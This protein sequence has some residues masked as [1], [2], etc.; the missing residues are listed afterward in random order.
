MKY[1]PILIAASLFAGCQQPT[2]KKTDS[3]VSTDTPAIPAFSPAGKSVYTYTTADKTDF[4]LA[5]TDTLTFSEMGQPKETQICVF[6]DPKRTYQTFMGIGGAITDASAE[7]LAKL[8]ADKQEELLKAYFDKEKGIGYSLLRTN[9]MSCDFSSGSYS[10]VQ[11]G[12]KELK[13]FSVEHDKQ[14]RIPMIKRAITAAGGTIPLYASPWSPPAFMKD[15]KNVLQGGKLLPEFYD[16][17][18]K[19]YVKF[20]QAYEA[21]G[22]PVWGI[23]IQNEPMA[24]QRWESCIYSAEEEANFLKKHLGPTMHASGM[25]DKKIIMWDHNRD[26]IYQRAQTYF[27]DPEVARYAWGIGFHW[28]ESWSG[29]DNTFDN[30]AMVHE[31]FPDE[32]IMFTEGCQEK[33]EASRYYEWKWAERYGRNMIMDFN[34]GAVGWTDWNIL[35]DENGGPNHVENFCFAPMH[36]DTKKGE[37]IYTNAYYYIGHFSKFIRPGAKRIISS[38][39]RSQLLSTSFVNEDGSIVVV[40]MN[41]S[42]LNTPFYLWID[43][44]AAETV[45]QPH[46]IN[47]YVIK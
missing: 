8:P 27:N 7:T 22:I 33:F 15:N 37:L 6:V 44:K 1:I 35:L 17:W 12:D 16:A 38:P 3:T 46:S 20:I 41:Q 9:I 29:G 19:F 36:G 5:L 13:S 21:E 47:T 31:A 26:L 30:V 39:S 45:A 24:T 25:K 28:Y 43:G 40:V 11:E 32:N 4:R 34:D 2:D 18:A 14:Y 23:S 10:Y 42:E